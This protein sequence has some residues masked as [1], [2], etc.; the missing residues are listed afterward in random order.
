M[1]VHSRQEF[2]DSLDLKDKYCAEIGVFRGDFSKMILEKDPLYLYLIDPWTV[3]EIKYKNGLPTAY[4]SNE[5]WL[6]VKREFRNDY[7]VVLLRDYSYNAVKT[8]NDDYFDFIYIDASHLKKDVQEDLDKWWHKMKDDGVIA[9][10]DYGNEEFPRVKDA[11]DWF[12][13]KY[14]FRMFLF[15]ENGGDYALKRI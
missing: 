9:G 1:I 7:R 6:F 2:L 12:C 14:Y 8:I 15:N 3:N 11:V 13:D 10:H 5:D 4:S